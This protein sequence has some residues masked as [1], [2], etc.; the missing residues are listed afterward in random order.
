LLS[1]L[2][3]H[4]IPLFL[5]I[6]SFI[7]FKG[8]SV[9]PV[10]NSFLSFCNLSSGKFCCF[11]SGF[12]LLAV[13]VSFPFFVFRE[14]L[15]YPLR[16]FTVCPDR[17]FFQ[18]LSSGKLAESPQVFYCLPWSFI[19]PIVVFRETC[20][21]PSGFYCCLIISYAIVFRE[22][23]LFPLRFL[24]V[25]WSCLYEIVFREILLFPLRF[26]TVS[27]DLSLCTQFLI[28]LILFL[29]SQ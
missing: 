20:C 28:H 4:F 25:P 27:P 21:I 3:L 19:F 23:L 17:L 24:T 7:H 15:L 6:P 26:L 9:S 11:P 5:V 18:F 10:F 13:I 14:T 12:S 2:L 8:F 22:I 1:S 29:L 16:F